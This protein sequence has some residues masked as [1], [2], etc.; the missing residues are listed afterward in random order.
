MI[1]IKILLQLIKHSKFLINTL[2]EH[3]ILPFLKKELK[4]AKRRDS[5]EEPR[6]LR[7]RDE[8]KTDQE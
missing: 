1:S 3:G 5:K 4:G 6:L 2:I 8:T 7:Y